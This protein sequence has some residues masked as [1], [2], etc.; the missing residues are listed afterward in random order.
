MSQSH[1]ESTKGDA[2]DSGARFTRVTW[3]PTA[4]ADGPAESSR[5]TL[6]LS[7]GVLE[8]PAA[9][10]W[11]S[12]VTAAAGLGDEAWKSGTTD[13]AAAAPPAPDASGALSA[14]GAGA[15]A[16]VADCARG[17]NATKAVARNRKIAA[18]LA[19]VD[20]VR[21]GA[22]QNGTDTRGTRDRDGTGIGS[23]A[24][25]RAVPRSSARRVRQS[26]HVSRCACT[27]ARASD[28]S[29]LSRY[30][31]SSPNGCTA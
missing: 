9:D 21:S 10:R 14:F 15:E 13:V 4:F 25:R 23:P 28:E 8:G 27:E 12:L 18:P 19:K 26:A 3:S 16:V 1:G 6:A 31:D 17:R 20:K 5:L 2:A 24:M 7:A 30:A 22:S 11:L 29:A